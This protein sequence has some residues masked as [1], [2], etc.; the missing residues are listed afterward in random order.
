MVLT[1]KHKMIMI[2]MA[3][4]LFLGVGLYDRVMSR[5]NVY[6]LSDASPVSSVDK[7]QPA[8]NGNDREITNNTSSP[9]EPVIEEPAVIVVHIEGEV[10]SPG[11]YELNE[12]SRVN[13]VVMMAGGLTQEADRRINLA[14]KLQDEAFVYVPSIG[15]ENVEDSHA[16]MPTSHNI[17]FQPAGA[18]QTSSLVNINTADQKSLE[19]LAGIGPVLAERI[20]A[21]R[22][23]QG[24]FQQLQ[25]LKKVTGI[26]DKR[27]QDIEKDITL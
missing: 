10:I 11:V 14:Q 15:E 12:G 18:T 6:V 20:I 1:R 22:E 23:E 19:T 13:D 3:L 7:G 16:L 26:G 9:V 5:K 24:P 27:Y 17:A 4:T 8:F 2:V 21:Y 25:D